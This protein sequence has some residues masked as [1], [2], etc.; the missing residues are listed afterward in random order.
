MREKRDRNDA[1][2]ICRLLG[3]PIPNSVD[4]G[5]LP[6]SRER[7]SRRQAVWVPG[8]SHVTTC[9]RSNDVVRD[10]EWREEK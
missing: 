5:D 9:C 6:N 3:K 2:A 4:I 7:A 10:R 1:G 8:K